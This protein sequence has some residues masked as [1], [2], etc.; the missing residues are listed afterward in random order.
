MRRITR[1]N[2]NRDMV[3]RESALKPSG[4]GGGLTMAELKNSPGPNHYENK[5]KAW[6][7]SMSQYD[8]TTKY[9]FGKEKNNSFID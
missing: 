7:T 2:M 9:T 6:K 8:T 1:A 5:D 4:G 3:K